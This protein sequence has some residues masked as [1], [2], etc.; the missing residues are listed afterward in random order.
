MDSAERAAAELAERRARQDERSAAME[1][2]LCRPGR[3]RSSGL[4]AGREFGRRLSEMPAAITRGRKM[5]RRFYFLFDCREPFDMTVER[6]KTKSGGRSGIR[7]L[8]GLSTLPVFH[9]T[10]AFATK[11]SLVCSLDFVFAIA[12]KSLRREPS[13][14]YTL[15]ACASLRSAL[16]RIFP[17]GSPTLTP[18]ICRVST[19]ALDLTR[20]VHSTALPTFRTHIV[21]HLSESSNSVGKA[22][23]HES[24]KIARCKLAEMSICAELVSAAWQAR[25][26]EM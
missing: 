8:E 15:L 20:P 12:Q 19:T 22:G 7:T 10:I 1:C 5:L 6:A 17:G 25:L 23:A 13:S 21:Q 3:I 2:E 11:P 18:Y 9:T 24:T 16:P 26:A 4:E 14:L